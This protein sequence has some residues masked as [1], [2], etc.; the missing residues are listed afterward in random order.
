MTFH[1]EARP[2]G[3]MRAYDLL[4]ITGYGYD[5]AGCRLV[6][7]AVCRVRGSGR[8]LG[9]IVPTSELHIVRDGAEVTRR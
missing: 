4:A 5:T 7:H 9:L 3:H 1:I 6:A 2:R 8:V